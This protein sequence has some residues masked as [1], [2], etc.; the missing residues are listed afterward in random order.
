[1]SELLEVQNLSVSFHSSPGI[2]QAV[3]NASFSVKSGEVLAIVGESGCGKSVLLRSIMKLLPSCARIESGRISL[4]GT[5]ITHYR[6]GQMR[7]LRGTLFSIV[8]QNPAAALNPTMSVG[9]QIAEA[10][11]LHRPCLSRSELQ[12]RTLELME[13]VGIDRPKDR[14]TQYPFH[15]S[16]GMLQRCV[17]AIAIAGNPKLLFADEPTTSL[18]TAAQE[19]ILK[20]LGELRKKLGTSIVLVSHDLGVVEKAADRVAVM[21]AG[22]IV[23]T[24]TVK[25]IYS[26]PRHPY[27]QG[28]MRSV[29]SLWA[30]ADT[31][32]TIPGMPPSPAAPPRGDAFACRNPYALRI[33]Y[34]KE[35]PMFRITDTHE[36]ATWLLDERAP[37]INLPV[38]KKRDGLRI[39]HT[40]NK[41]ILLDVRHLTHV[42]PLTKK[43]SIKAV[44]DVSFQIYTGEIFGLVGESGCGKS[45]VARCVMNLYRPEGGSVFYKGINLSDPRA[46]R[47]NRR[48]LQTARQIIFQDS[49]SSLNPR[50]RVVDLVTE[51][52]RIRRITPKRGSLR[53]EAVFQLRCVGLDEDYLDKHPWELSGG[54]RQ[55]VAIARALI[56]EPELIVADEP[57]T[58]LDV[59]VQ[60]QILN[61]FRHLQRECGFSFL[62]ITHDLAAA[63]FLCS[64]IGIMRQGSLAQITIP[65][66]GKYD[67]GGLYDD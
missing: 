16:G 51:P 18:D 26:D 34:E 2:L 54:Q 49:S 45:T 22:K 43:T 57:T 30:G 21:Y 24:G 3:R 39:P 46:F 25:E 56:A 52:L 42:F 19:K 10:V 23:E 50:M 37:K 59:S 28:L 55:R 17:I 40:K 44:D 33:D 6:E 60:A 38:I 65:D 64:R 20:L 14:M 31:L 27:T 12:S 48:M 61:L 35:P 47:R 4:C 29:P 9:S 15:F 11:R 5:D 7:R 58:A 67:K 13:L 62:F 53:Q 32:Y 41:E 63:Q 1:M 66:P 36:A 8:P